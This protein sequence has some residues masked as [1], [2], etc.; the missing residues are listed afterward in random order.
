MSE[1]VKRRTGGQ[2]EKGQSGN[3]AGARTR[4]RKEL[5]TVEDF[6]N[7]I[8]RVAY[9]PT[10]ISINKVSHKVSLLE[11]N[12]WQL[13]S[14]KAPNRLAAMDSIELAKSATYVLERAERDRQREEL[15]QARRERGY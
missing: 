1:N 6:H 2:F 13:F 5:R 3:P 12:I 4:K 14:G 7:M 9:S 10:E 11:A 15:E 8:L